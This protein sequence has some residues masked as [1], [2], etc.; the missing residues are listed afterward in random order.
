[1]TPQE[2][3]AW[4]AIMLAVLAFAAVILIALDFAR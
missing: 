1:M 3:E 2:R 4:L